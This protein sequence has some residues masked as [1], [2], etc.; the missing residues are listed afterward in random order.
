[1][2]HMKSPTRS[3]YTASTYHRST[4]IFTINKQSESYYMKKHP[5]SVYF[6]VWYLLNNINISVINL[7]LSCGQASHFV[8]IRDRE[9]ITETPIRSFFD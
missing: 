5:P 6:C 8:F 9:N 1:M 2:P 7:T 3:L 4:Y